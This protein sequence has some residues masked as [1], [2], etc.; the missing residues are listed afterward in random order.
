M[1]I[2]IRISAEKDIHEIY[3]W[4]EKQLNGLGKRFLEDFQ[5]TIPYLNTYPKSFRLKYKSFRTIPLSEF[6][7]LVYF[8]I[9]KQSIIIQKVG[10]SHRNKRKLKF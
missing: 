9:Q 5:Q 2:I 7:Y 8:R 3:N 1:D 6:P 10:H 4:Y